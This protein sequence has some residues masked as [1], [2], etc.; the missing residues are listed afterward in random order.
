[1]MTNAPGASFLPDRR[2]HLRADVQ[3]AQE[4]RGERSRRSK[5]FGWALTKGQPQAISLDY[6]PLPAPLVKRIQGYVGANIK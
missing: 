4:C 2:D 1:M 6:V 5:F 3:A